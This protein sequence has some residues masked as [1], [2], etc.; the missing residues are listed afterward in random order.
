[1]VRKRN[2]KGKMY[3]FSRDDT[4]FNQI[5]ETFELYQP[6]KQSRKQEIKANS[7]FMAD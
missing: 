2:V 6:D 5:N 1:M 7:L 4:L 3:V